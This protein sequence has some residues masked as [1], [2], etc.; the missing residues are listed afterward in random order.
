MSPTLRLNVVAIAALSSVILFFGLSAL[1]YFAIK[2]A[3]LVCFLFWFFLSVWYDQKWRTFSKIY[4]KNFAATSAMY[5]N[6]ELPL[7]NWTD[8]ILLVGMI[9]LFFAYF[10]LVIKGV[11]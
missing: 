5:R 3:C 10:T 11:S 2:N 6:K 9:V 1:G 4:N 7:P 8:K